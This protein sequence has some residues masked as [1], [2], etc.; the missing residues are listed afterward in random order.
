VFFSRAL[1]DHMEECLEARKE[2]N[3]RIDESNKRIDAGFGEARRKID[4]RH[5]QNQT[6]IR[7]LDSKTQTSIKALDEKTQQSF[8][9][10]YNSL[11]RVMLWI[12]GAFAL[13]YLA[14]HGFTAPGLEH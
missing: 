14:Q 4:E 2:T 7:D 5:E 3:R 8:S 1:K 10:L 12:L 6:A 13:S 11:W 9:K